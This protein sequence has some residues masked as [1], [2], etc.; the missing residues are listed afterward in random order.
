MHFH[1]AG[2]ETWLE[3]YSNAAPT[4]FIHRKLVK[5]NPIKCVCTLS[6]LHTAALWFVLITNIFIV[7]VCNKYDSH[8][9][10]PARYEDGEALYEL[11]R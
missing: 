10:R 5:S 4:W 2:L 7:G 11:T 9:L 6:G 3:Q 8:I 1:V